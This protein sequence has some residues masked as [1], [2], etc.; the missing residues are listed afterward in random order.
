MEHFYIVCL[1][2]SESTSQEKLKQ[3]HE[4]KVKLTFKILEL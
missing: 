3:A 2:I 4:E 1:Q